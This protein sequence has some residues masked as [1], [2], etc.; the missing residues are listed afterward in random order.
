MSVIVS[1]DDNEFEYNIQEF[2]LEN[3]KDKYLDGAIKAAIDKLDEEFYKVSMVYRKKYQTYL[4]LSLESRKRDLS[5]KE[6]DVISNIE[7]TIKN[8][9]SDDESANLETEDNENNNIYP[10][11]SWT[12]VLDTDA[13]NKRSSLEYV[14][15]VN[16]VDDYK[17]VDGE[18]ERV[19][20][21]QENDDDDDHYR[22]ENDEDGNFLLNLR[23]QRV[24]ED[25]ESEDVPNNPNIQILPD[26]IENNIPPTKEEDKYLKYKIPLTILAILLVIMLLITQLMVIAFWIW[27]ICMVVTLPFAIINEKKIG[28]FKFSRFAQNTAIGPVFIYKYMKK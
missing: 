8:L 23:E 2:I 28:K 20:I 9:S 25:V 22:Q 7:F 5:Q 12:Q 17:I 4:E 3:N 1:N 14:N 24:I 16:N 15:R 19:E 18:I 26:N 27:I 10:D 11:N 21:P 6:K 13:N